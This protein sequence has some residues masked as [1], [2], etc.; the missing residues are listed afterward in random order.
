[1]ED[2]ITFGCFLFLSS[3]LVFFGSRAGTNGVGT[4]FYH[5]PMEVEI[6]KRRIR[7]TVAIELYR[8]VVGLISSYDCVQR[9]IVSFFVSFSFL[10]LKL[11]L[12]AQQVCT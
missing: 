4:G 12:A 6:P 5:L 1:M 7:Q 10:S 9:M 3:L 11:A 8:S 2:R